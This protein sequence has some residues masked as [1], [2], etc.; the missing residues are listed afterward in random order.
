MMRMI[1]IVMM[2]VY[3][4]VLPTA[5]KTYP[6]DPLIHLIHTHTHS[7]APTGPSFFTKKWTVGPWIVGPNTTYSCTNPKSRD[8]RLELDNSRLTLDEK[9]LIRD[10]N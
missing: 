5:V 4:K 6:G 9:C 7:D 10:E 3:E 2:R 1:S 8:S